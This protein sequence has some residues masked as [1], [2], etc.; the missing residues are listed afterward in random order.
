MSDDDGM[1]G[2]PGDQ[3]HDQDEEQDEEFDVDGA[4]REDGPAGRFDPTP[5][6]RQLGGR[7]GPGQE[8]LDVKWRLLWLRK[9]HPDAQIVT[10]HVR[11]DDGI[12]IFKATVTLPSGGKATGYGSETAGDF[13]D[14]I[15]KAETKA[16]GRALNAL[17][18]GAQ[19]SERGEEDATASGPPPA[20][21]A[22]PA[23]AAPSPPAAPPRGQAGPPAEPPRPIERPTPIPAPAPAEPTAIQEPPAPVPFRPAAERPAPAEAPGRRE[24]T[25]APV[26]GPRPVPVPAPAAAGAGDD[27]AMAD[28]SWNDFWTWARTLGYR[29]RD[30]VEEFLGRPIEGLTPGEVRGL[31]RDRQS[32]D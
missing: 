1:R 6:L 12:A 2:G 9:E 19:F 27:E 5:Y 8:Y 14:F 17:G 11:I 15:E 20:P 22:R 31:I 13:G 28:V 16:I 24:Q 7:R 32:E 21:P 3:D 18:Y 29:K 26:R 4:I 30:E 23:A 10:E 25:P